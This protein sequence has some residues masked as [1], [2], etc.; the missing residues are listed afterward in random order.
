MS[1]NL[2]KGI[3][4]CI[5]ELFDEL[6]YQYAYYNELIFILLYFLNIRK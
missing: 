6:S 5:I 2:A 1:R 4:D 3:E